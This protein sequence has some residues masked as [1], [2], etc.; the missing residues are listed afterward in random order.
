MNPVTLTS[1]PTVGAIA[2]SLSKAQA[3][4]AAIRETEKADI[5]TKAGRMQ[6]GYATLADII[7]GVRGPL[8]DQGIAFVQQT[9]PTDTVG[10]VWIVTTLIHESGEWLSTHLRMTVTNNDPR[11]LGSALT[12]GFRYSLRA[13]CGLPVIGEDDDGNAAGFGQD[14]DTSPLI[15]H[16]AEL[17]FL[18]AKAEVLFGDKGPA[19]LQ[20]LAVRRFRIP[21]GDWKMIP[22][23]R[24]TY[25]VTAL[26]KKSNEP[27]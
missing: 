4:M 25:A 10:D 24:L 2:L 15:E 3:A 21:D 13:I 5:P 7:L 23:N 12:Y 18:E 20:S 22:R 8:A 17:A 6:Y 1:S 9:W 16:P 27:T 11:V 19:T 14:D 26:E